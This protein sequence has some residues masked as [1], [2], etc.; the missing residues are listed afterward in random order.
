M[1]RSIRQGTREH[2]LLLRCSGITRQAQQVGSTGKEG[3]V[4]LGRIENNIQI[5]LSQRDGAWRTREGCVQRQA[6]VL[7]RD[8]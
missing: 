1:Y 7:G 3:A 4:E 2:G 5:P 6:M 8:R